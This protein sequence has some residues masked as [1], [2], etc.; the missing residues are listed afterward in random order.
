ADAYR[1]F[2]VREIQ[3]GQDGNFSW[4]SM[5]ARYTSELANGLGNLASRVLSMAGS[6]FEARVPEPS[7]RTVGGA[8][9]SAADGLADEVCRRLDALELNEAFGA[10]D[11]FVR[12]ANRYLVEVAPW[13][14]AKDPARRQ[15]LADSLYAALE[16]L[17]VIAVLAGPVMPNLAQE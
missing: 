7:S 14:L 17:R 3:W 5:A 1:W 13:T 16:A 6:Y 10:L 2:V 11:G 15:D 4:E 12:E 8:L 9:A